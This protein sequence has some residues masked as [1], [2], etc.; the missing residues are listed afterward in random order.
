MQ[1]VGK[2]S[3]VMLVALAVAAADRVRLPV[4]AVWTLVAGLV[5]MPAPV[6]R[7]AGVGA[8]EA[9]GRG[10]DIGTFRSPPPPLPGRTVLVKS[11]ATT[12]EL[13]L[14]NGRS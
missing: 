1:P 4:V 11:R 8:Q 14:T 12:C 5:G 3:T 2:R 10:G 13:C 7:V 9:R 6:D